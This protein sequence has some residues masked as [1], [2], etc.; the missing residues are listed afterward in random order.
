MIASVTY[1]QFDFSLA[2]PKL[3]RPRVIAAIILLKNK[4]KILN[5]S[6]G[7]IGDG[8]IQAREGL[9]LKSGKA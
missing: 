8:I 4:P 5:A 6:Q 9:E 7:E 2:I 3:T 1:Q